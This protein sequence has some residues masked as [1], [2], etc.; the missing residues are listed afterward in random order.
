MRLTKA[1]VIAL[2]HRHTSTIPSMNAAS[3]VRCYSPNVS[4]GMKDL[5]EKDPKVK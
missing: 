4:K 5:K 2:T 1:V 3:T